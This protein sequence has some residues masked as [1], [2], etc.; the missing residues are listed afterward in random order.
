ME[1]PIDR[2]GRE[3]R[4]LGDV[5]SAL[6]DQHVNILSSETRTGTDRITTMRFDFELGDPSHLGDLVRAIKAIDGVYDAYRVLRG[7]GS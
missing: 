7:K 5:S 2:R 1:H 6:A 3:P 4:L